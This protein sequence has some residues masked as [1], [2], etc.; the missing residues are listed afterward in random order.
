MMKDHWTKLL[1]DMDREDSN[2]SRRY[3]RY[4]ISYDW[5]GDVFSK[6]EFADF[7]EKRELLES[8]IAKLTWK[9]R[10]LIRLLYFEGYSQ[11]E[12]AEKLNCSKGA[13]SLLKKQALLN[14]Q[15]NM[16]HKK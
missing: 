15:K 13:V 8:A 9:Q 2:A 3:R 10:R 5:K 4:N 1:S 12:A 7:D 14:L 16:S 6:V 11:T